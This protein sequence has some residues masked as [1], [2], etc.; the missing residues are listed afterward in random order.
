MGTHGTRGKSALTKPKPPPK[1]NGRPRT[2][3][4]QEIHDALREPTLRAIAVL[5][6]LQL[7]AEQREKRG[8]SAPSEADR[9]RLLAAKALVELGSRPPPPVVPDPDAKPKPV[10]VKVRYADPNAVNASA[11]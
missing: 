7:T 9:T 3:I 2:T 10:E 1:A 6:E 5:D 11:I 8:L 4:P